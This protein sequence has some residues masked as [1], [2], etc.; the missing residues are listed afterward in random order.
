MRI[1]A[2]SYSY[3]QR[4]AQL[5]RRLVGAELRERLERAEEAVKED[6]ICAEI[7]WLRAHL[8]SRHR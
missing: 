1:S 2:R 6:A 7:E 5:E 8:L 4:L 3:S